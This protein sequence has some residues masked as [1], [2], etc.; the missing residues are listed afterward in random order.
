MPDAVLAG[1]DVVLGLLF[2]YGQ[3]E[4]QMTHRIIQA[5]ETRTSTS[6]PIPPAAY[7]VKERQWRK[8]RGRLRRARAHNK[9]LEIS[10]MPTASTL[11]IPTFPGTRTGVKLVINTDAHQRAQLTSCVLG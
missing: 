10:A 5:I 4:D 11:R 7:S 3:N 8:H 6:S 1:L 9:A 2:Q